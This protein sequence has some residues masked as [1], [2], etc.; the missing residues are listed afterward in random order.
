VA[1]IKALAIDQLNAM[2][3]IAAALEAI[4][5]PSIATREDE[6][7]ACAQICDRFTKRGDKNIGREA[8]KLIRKR[9]SSEEWERD[10]A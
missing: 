3:R 8:A 5:K 10:N 9:Q 2:K 7:E 4:A 1:E 6:R